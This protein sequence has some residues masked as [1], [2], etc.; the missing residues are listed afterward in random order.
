MKL[1]MF[2]VTKYFSFLSTVNCNFGQGP[3]GT[4]QT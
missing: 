3:V 4:Y 1:G 2:F